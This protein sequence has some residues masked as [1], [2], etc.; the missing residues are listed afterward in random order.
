MT[1]QTLVTSR[2]GEANGQRTRPDDQRGA[3]F[4]R[5]IALDELWLRGLRF[6]RL[7]GERQERARGDGVGAARGPVLVPDPARELGRQKARDMRVAS[8]GHALTVETGQREQVVS[9]FAVRP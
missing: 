2:L 8:S 3:S 9:P 4:S 1:T 6:P 7:A 5:P